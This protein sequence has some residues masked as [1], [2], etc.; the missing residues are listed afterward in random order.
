MLGKQKAAV[1]VKE[2]YHPIPD[3]QEASHA[4][5]KCP[6]QILALLWLH[7]VAVRSLQ[8]PQDLH[9]P[10]KHDRP[11]CEVLKTV[12]SNLSHWNLESL[13]YLSYGPLHCEILDI[14]IF[15]PLDSHV[16]EDFQSSSAETTTPSLL[17]MIDRRS[18]ITFLNQISI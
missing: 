5:F 3:F 4:A 18:C 6:S 15:Q 16:V 1:L 7:H 8:L 10:Q 2:V 11:C 14:N 13:H 12:R 9:I 17:S